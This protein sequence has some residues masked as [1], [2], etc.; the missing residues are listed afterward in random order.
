MSSRVLKCLLPAAACILSP[1]ALRAEVFWRLPRT[2]DTALQEQGGTRVYAT[3]VQINGTPGMLATYVFAA[4]AQSVSAGL[5]RRLGLPPAAPFG[6]TLVTHLEKGRMR[7]LMILPSDGAEACVVLSL[8]Q[9]LD[10]YT[11]ALKEPPTWPD[12]LPALSASP[13]FSAVCAGTRTAFVTAESA[14]SPEEAVQEAAQMLLSTGWAE[15]SPSAP[16]F[17]IFASGRKVCILLASRNA[18]S[19]RTTISVL[20]REGANP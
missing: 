4:S 7:R 17:K 18:Q 15:T 14:S 8:D 6:G 10:D 11:R 12:G 9:S 2:A 1:L 13:L 5:V 19:E 16:A 20:Q 3:A